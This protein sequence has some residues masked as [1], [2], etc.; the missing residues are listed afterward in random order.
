LTVNNRSRLEAAASRRPEGAVDANQ[1]VGALLGTF[2][3]DALGMPWEGVSVDTIPRVIELVDAR[4]GAGTYTDDTE[5]TIAVAE[6]LLR[7]D[8][9]DED[10]LARTF[11]ALHD[12]RRGYGRS[13]LRVLEL[14][15]GGVAPQEAA[16]RIFDGD[17]SLGNGA[18]MRIA[19]IAVR[20]HD[21]KVLLNTQARRSARLTH[22]HPVGIDGA[23]V[24]A[25]AIATALDGTNPFEAA[26][27]AAVTSQVRATLANAWRRTDAALD[28]AALGD[29][30]G[31]PARADLSVAAAIVAATRADSFEAAV[32]TAIRAGGDTD[33]TGAMAGA[34]AGARFD[35]S[36]IPERW[37][38]G[39]ED[40]E[41]GRRHGRGTGQAAR[42]ARA[43]SGDESA[44]SG[45]SRSSRNP[46]WRILGSDPAA[47]GPARRC[48]GCSRG[49]PRAPARRAAERR[50]AIPAAGIIASGALGAG[51]SAG[52]RATL[53]RGRAR[54]IIDEGG[55]DRRYEA[56]LAHLFAYWEHD[57]GGCRSPLACRE[58]SRRPEHGPCGPG[59]DPVGAGVHRPRYAEDHLSAGPSA[60]DAIPTAIYCGSLGLRF[61]DAVSDARDATSG[62]NAMPAACRSRLTAIDSDH[63][64]PT[65][66]AQA[67]D[68][69]VGNRFSPQRSPCPRGSQH[70]DRS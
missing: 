13:V 40:G 22:V 3:G 54:A 43:S 24:Q 37:L 11:L 15:R 41:R 57:T 20:F 31:V 35:A 64:M 23:A 28:P 27:R 16:S 30:R 6:S 32:T 49:A 14:W 52:P 29:G 1:A 66:L 36:A 18:A 26:S 12:P 67:I 8:V 42:G 17:G 70:P 68:P 63:A 44:P 25:A 33:T 62:Q 5:M 47:A 58:R 10:D 9:V 4:L 34:I 2:V 69:A 51:G 60:A 38:D 45:V 55:C 7:C 39:L 53:A 65:A 19:P 46:R 48:G 56:E 50:L 61:S 21:D 59:P